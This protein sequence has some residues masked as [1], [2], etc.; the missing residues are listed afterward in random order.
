LKRE[1]EFKRSEYYSQVEEEKR[2]ALQRDMDSFYAMKER[3]VTAP[4]AK[5]RIDMEAATTNPIAFK[6]RE[7]KTPN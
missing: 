1:A 2:L 7:F 5:L 6:P 3:W 4:E